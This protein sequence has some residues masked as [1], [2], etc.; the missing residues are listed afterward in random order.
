[1]DRCKKVVTINILLTMRAS[2]YDETEKNKTVQYQMLD[3][4]LSKSCYEHKKYKG[5]L[6]VTEAKYLERI[7]S[8]WKL[9]NCCLTH[10]RLTKY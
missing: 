2:I 8:S 1:M 9:A 5:T 3:H 7:W 6:C 10:Q 4:G